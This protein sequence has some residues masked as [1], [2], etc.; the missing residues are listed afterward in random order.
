MDKIDLVDDNGR[1]FVRLSYGPDGEQVL[2]PDILFDPEKL[3]YHLRA[4]MDYWT[5]NAT[6]DPARSQMNPV[7]MLEQSIKANK[8]RVAN[9]FPVYFNAHRKGWAKR[10]MSME[11]VTFDVTRRKDSLAC[12]YMGIVQFKAGL[13]QS[14]FFKTK[15]EAEIARRYETLGSAD[16]CRLEYA[17]QVDRWV[18]LSR[19]YYSVGAWSD[20]NVSEPESWPTVLLLMLR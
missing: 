13:Q 20:A 19:Q 4:W 5:E 8:A 14:P 17:F 7:A 11:D 10:K 2:T 3:A 1:L 16:P 18:I 15:E 6:S 9:A 12:P